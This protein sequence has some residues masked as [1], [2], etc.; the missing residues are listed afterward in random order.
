MLGTTFGME[1]EPSGR[2]AVVVLGYDLWR[3][4]FRGD[5]GI[6]GRSIQLNGTSYAVIGVMPRGFQLFD[7]Q[8]DLWY[9]LTMSQDQQ[10]WTGATA[11][12]YG[13]LRSGQSA[14]LASVEMRS[15][16]TAMQAEFHLAPDW[17]TGAR[18]EGLLEAVVGS[19]SR[20]I[21]LLFGGVVFL[22]LIATANVTNL[23]L[24]RAAERRQELS[25]RL[26]LGASA[27]R[28]ARLLFTES[29]MLSAIG[30]ACG[31]AAAFVI[32]RFL[33]AM[34]PRD[35]PRIGEVALS[36]AVLA[37]AVVATVLPAIVFGFVPLL[38]TRTSGLA[39][40]LRETKGGRSGEFARG[41]L[42]SAEVGLALVLVVGTALM[43]RSLSALL[44][45]DVGLKADHLL[46]AR[47][48]PTGMQSVEETRVFWREVFSRVEALPGVRGAATI[49]HLPASGRSWGANIEVE[50]RPTS[51]DAPTPRA[52][53]QSVSTK[54]FATAGV[55]VQVGRGVEP[56][57]VAGSP[58][59]IVVNAPFA[60][61]FFPGENPVG[62]RIKAGFATDR[63]WAT[64]VGV[65]GGVRH[66]S[67]NAPPVPEVY[68]PFEQHSVWATSLV[69]RYTG[70]A[71]ALAPA[72][73]NAIWSVRRDVPVDEMRTMD[74]VLS[75]SLQRPRLILE[76][77]GIFAA[78]GLLLGAVGIYGVTAFG[79][80]QRR[81]E[82]GIR[83]ALGATAERLVWLVV[84]GGLRYAVI[85][86]AIGVP[87]SF[88]LSRVMRGLVFGVTPTDPLSFGLGAFVLVAVAA[89]AS[90]VPARSASRTEP[91]EVLR[92]E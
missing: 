64:I 71:T 72:I 50:G 4:T 16:A 24:V 77:L 68:V 66:D 80:E 85:G 9:P 90:W 45:V 44:S 54:F 83:A 87:V 63:E 48:Q 7:W 3:S 61:S 25:L 58:R 2:D 33:P 37:F 86:V 79:V 59:V 30:G 31:I 18:V 32:V 14:A 43:G 28:I 74:A 39:G 67:L 82:L 21:W 41:A 19:A 49:L 1:A 73:R 91:M 84:R 34:L 81:R 27:S 13:R 56:T 10:S 55:P 8:S 29:V 53:W 76:L 52:A 15:M 70:D 60:K 40:A 36:P 47:V 62:H 35:L 23:L 20:M 22:L 5:S 17:A 12:A 6:V 38:Q 69:V 26:A 92:G 65:V 11:Q 89:L 42:I 51:P 46:T 88:A 78:T 75:G 57:D